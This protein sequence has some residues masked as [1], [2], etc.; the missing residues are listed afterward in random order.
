M[1]VISH[2][3]TA[4]LRELNRGLVHGC[5]SSGKSGQMP[6]APTSDCHIIPRCALG[7]KERE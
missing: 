1:S 7:R 3:I 2:E 6:R 5:F 4:L